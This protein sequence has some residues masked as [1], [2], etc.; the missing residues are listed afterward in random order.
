MEDNRAPLDIITPD[1]YRAPS[2][3]IQI[4]THIAEAPGCCD[5]DII[6]DVLMGGTA[7]THDGD[8]IGH[9]DGDVITLAE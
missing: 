1:G 4:G 9:I 5:A 3:Y 8:V 7:V 2:G 6:G